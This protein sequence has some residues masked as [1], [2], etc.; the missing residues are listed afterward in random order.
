MIHLY[1][2]QAIVQKEFA[3]YLDEKPVAQSNFYQ[4]FVGEVGHENGVSEDELVGKI[5]IRFIISKEGK[6]EDITVL[7]GVHGTV[8]EE[9]VRLLQEAPEWSPGMKDG[10]PVDTPMILPVMSYSK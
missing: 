1:V 10:E 9:I 8:N 2:Q 4:H 7:R 5:I 3:E 6:T